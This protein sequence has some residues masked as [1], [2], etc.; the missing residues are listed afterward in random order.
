MDTGGI[1]SASCRAASCTAGR[2]IHKITRE[3]GRGTAATRGCRL[4][5][6]RWDR[7]SDGLAT[8]AAGN[9]YLSARLRY[10]IELRA[11]RTLDDR[12]QMMQASTP[13]YI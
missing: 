6:I 4:R 5:I 8:M 2:Y 1:V 3:D 7:R 9:R 12:R 10:G 11:P 13:D